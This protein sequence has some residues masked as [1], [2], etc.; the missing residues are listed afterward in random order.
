MENIINE[1]EKKLEINKNYIVQL[2]MVNFKRFQTTRSK[3]FI[4]LR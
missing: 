3:Y 1:I 4:I 2:V